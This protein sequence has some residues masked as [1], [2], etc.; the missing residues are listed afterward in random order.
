MCIWHFG[1]P[2]KLLCMKRGAG[3]C[4]AST[5]GST[6]AAS[7]SDNSL[8]NLHNRGFTIGGEG[9]VFENGKLVLPPQEGRAHRMVLCQIG[10]GKSFVVEES[11]RAIWALP[12]GYDSIY[13]SGQ[14]SSPGVAPGG[15]QRVPP[16]VHSFQFRASTSHVPRPIFHGTRRKRPPGAPRLARAPRSARNTRAV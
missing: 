10:V 15:L 14:S 1:N 5:R 13:L 9:M 8:E 4:F 2:T 7:G 11:G 12:S 6:S 16:R 3:A